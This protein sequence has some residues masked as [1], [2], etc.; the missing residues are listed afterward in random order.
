MSLLTNENS[1]LLWHDVIK[2]AEYRSSISL[3]E[4]LETYLVSLLIRYTNKPEIAKT[5]VATKFLEA[6]QQHEFQ[7]NSSLRIVGDDCLIYAGL[8]PKLAEKRHVK[9]GYFINLGRSAYAAITGTANDLY[10]TIAIQFVSMMDVLQSIPES[11][12]LLPLEAFE[13]WEE[14][15]SQRAFRILQ[16]YSSSLPLGKYK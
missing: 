10:S 6:M 5:I 15:G 11:S 14:S 12:T 8:F 9:L 2:H 4:D 7:R 16:G 3:K 1:T 13:L